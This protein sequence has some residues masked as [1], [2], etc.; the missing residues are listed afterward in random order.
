MTVDASKILIEI[1]RMTFRKYEALISKK[2]NGTL[3]PVERSQMST[4]EKCQPN[5]CPACGVKVWSSSPPARVVHDV[6]A[7]VNRQNHAR[8]LN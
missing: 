7:C 1:S 2:N 4:F 3:M 5:E 8:N 6:P